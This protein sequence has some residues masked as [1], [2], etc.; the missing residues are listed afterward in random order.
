MEKKLVNP[1][2][3]IIRFGAEDVIAASPTGED[4]GED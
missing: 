3:E 1:E 4:G 2:M